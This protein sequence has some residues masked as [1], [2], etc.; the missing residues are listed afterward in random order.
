M[1]GILAIVGVLTLLVCGVFFLFSADTYRAYHRS[2][3]IRC[4]VFGAALIG[5][6]VTGDWRLV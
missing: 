6:A 3:I 5:L 4:R 1:T 2:E